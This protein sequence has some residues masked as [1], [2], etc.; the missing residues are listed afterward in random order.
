MA[1]DV[2]A[3]APQQSA[4]ARGPGTLLS[5]GR[6]LTVR[7]IAIAWVGLGVLGTLVFAPHVRHGGFYLDDWA[8]AAEALRSPGGSSFGHV[9]T[10]FWNLT[11]YRPVLVLYVPLT[12][13]VFGTHMAYMLAWVAVLAMFVAAML[14][15]IL[16]TLGVP[17]IHAWL[18][19]ALAMVYP[20]F[21]S[22]RFWEGA[23][24]ASLSIAFASA[25]LWI[26]LVALSRR[27]LRLHVCASL[28]YLLSILTY[29]IA[30]PLIASAGV[31]YTLRAGWR[32]A[33]AR[34]A[35]DL[36]VVIAGGLWVGLHTPR[37]K[38]GISGDLTHLKMIV[39][40][41]G[42]ILGRTVIPVGE[43]RT[44]LAIVIFALIAVAGLAARLRW[45]AKFPKA[46][47]WGLHSW[48]LLLGGGLLVAA[49]GWI[50]FI[51]ANPYYTP[52]VYGFTNRV[53]ALA[54]FGLVIAVYGALGTVGALVGQLRPNAR[55][56]AG[57]ITVLLALVFGVA[58]VRVLERHSRIWNTAYSAEAAAVSVM[59]TQLHYLPPGTTVFASNYPAYQTLGVPIFAVQYDIDG[60]IK[61]QYKDGSLS[62]YSVVPGLSLQCRANGVGLIG[63]GAPTVTAA[64]G[65]ARLLNLQTGQH[66]RPRDERECRAEAGGY[67]P[68]PLY[69][70]LTY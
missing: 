1:I 14:Y 54:G 34:W 21:D 30:L 57:A 47:G 60:M 55:A 7:E 8:N 42:T 20:W 69:L 37:E 4:T 45:R 48:L 67:M 2:Q 51:P 36:A 10:Y 33:R 68:G 44:T 29:E 64:Y 26:A 11:D 46:I 39:T 16:R 66:S 62:A 13:F 41:G 50:I 28:L 24:Q 35:I 70:S 38:Q 63:E 27:S 19:A 32:A 23:S 3:A 59:R 6:S 52:S 49:L 9:L 25:G 12:Y 31:L 65:A 56:M 40:S 18:I 58:Y 22:T 15:G 5:S 43:Q 17:W 61:L 53:N